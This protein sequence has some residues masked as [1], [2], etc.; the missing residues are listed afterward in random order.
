MMIIKDDDDITLLLWMGI[1]CD[2]WDPG[3]RALEGQILR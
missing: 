2:G 1:I 3:I